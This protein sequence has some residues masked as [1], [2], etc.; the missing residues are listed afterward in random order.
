MA[1]FTLPGSQLTYFLLCDCSDCP[2]RQQCFSGTP[3]KMPDE[4]SS[5][6]KPT[7]AQKP[8]GGRGSPA[9]TIWTPLMG[10]KG[11][12]GNVASDAAVDEVKSQFFCGASWG[13]LVADCEAAKPCPS[14]TNAECEGGQSCFAN[15]GC[16]KAPAP[17]PEEYI[18]PGIFNFAAMV[19]KV[20]PF[21][22][23]ADTMSRNV[24]YWQSWSI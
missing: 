4:P 5:A 24:G 22:K 21:C 9:P 18:P 16:G 1:S 15:T 23:D 8:S 14:G 12:S 2:K 3:C 11:G 13:E 6:D 19:E 10:D 17:P 7:P 20:P